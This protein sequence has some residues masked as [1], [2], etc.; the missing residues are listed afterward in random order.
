VPPRQ[1]RVEKGDQYLDRKSQKVKVAVLANLRL[2]SLDERFV[3]INRFVQ[4]IYLFY[5]R[6]SEAALVLKRKFSVVNLTK[7]VNCTYLTV[8]S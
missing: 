3:K 4:L 5:L 6:A 1:E 8:V 7:Y 2:R